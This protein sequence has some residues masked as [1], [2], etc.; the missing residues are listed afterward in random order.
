MFIE[1]LFIIAK[2]WMQPKC[3]SVGEFS[4]QM[5]CGI[6]RQGNIIWCQK[7]MSY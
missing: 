7:E 4:R 3:N 5:N 6:P 2:T 1:G